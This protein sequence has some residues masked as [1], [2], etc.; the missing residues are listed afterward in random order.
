MQTQPLEIFFLRHIFA[1]CKNPFFIKIFQILFV[2]FLLLAKILS[3]S[4]FSK[5]CLSYFCSLQK[6]FL[7]QNFPNFV[8]H[9]FAPC[10]NPFFIKIF[11]ILFVIFLLLAKILSLS[12][13]S[14]FCLSSFCSLQKS[15]LY[16]NF[17][18]FVCH[19]KFSSLT[20][21]SSHKTLPYSSLL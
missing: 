18:N 4:K 10:K 7:Y 1:P 8:C 19:F 12:K 17:P 21:T 13:F 9:I 16:Q 20:K 2:I 11:Q 15:F 5:F 3:L 6:S 14:K